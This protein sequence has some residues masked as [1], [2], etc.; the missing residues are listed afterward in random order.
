MPIIGKHYKD[1]PYWGYLPES[2]YQA[3]TAV[4]ATR[5]SL[6]AQGRE[7]R[8]AIRAAG[9][10]HKGMGMTKAGAVAKA[11]AI[12]ARFPGIVIH[13]YSHDYL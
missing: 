4:G 2:T 10:K 12:E 1:C 9:Y 6:R 13:V 3:V 8:K 11:K 5:E 7:E